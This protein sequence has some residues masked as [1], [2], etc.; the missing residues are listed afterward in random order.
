MLNYDWS[1]EVITHPAPAK[2]L[3]RG[4]AAASTLLLSDLDRAAPSLDTC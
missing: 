2:M 3:S 4:S 1:S